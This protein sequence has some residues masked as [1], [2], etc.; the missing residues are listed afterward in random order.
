VAN[1]VE[2]E[3]M[4]EREKKQSRNLLVRFVAVGQTS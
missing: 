1:E 3:A 2:E 4:G